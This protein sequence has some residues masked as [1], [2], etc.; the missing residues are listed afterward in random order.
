MLLATVIAKPDLQKKVKNSIVLAKP[1]FIY[2]HVHAHAHA[3]ASSEAQTNKCPHLV[4]L[5]GNGGR[6]RGEGI[7]YFK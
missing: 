3:Q 2:A 6:H 4:F 1:V 5:G 7:I